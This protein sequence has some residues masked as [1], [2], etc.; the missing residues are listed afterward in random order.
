MSSEPIKTQSN[1]GDKC[2]K[3]TKAQQ[4]PRGEVTK[5]D[6]RG[7]RP[8]FWGLISDLWIDIP[9]SGRLLSKI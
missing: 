2:R 6:N 7:T 4:V 9:L 3:K 5:K 1:F 8:T